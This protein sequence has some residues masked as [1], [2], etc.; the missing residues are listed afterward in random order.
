MI[1]SLPSSTLSYSKNI[2]QPNIASKAKKIMTKQPISQIVSRISLMQNDVCLKR[3][4]Q[5]NTL[6]HRS[7]TPNAA[8]MRQYFRSG[9]SISRLLTATMYAERRQVYKSIQLDTVLTQSQKGM[10]KLCTTSM[11]TQ[12]M[13]KMQIK[14]LRQYSQI[15]YSV[16]RSSPKSSCKTV[17]QKYMEQSA[18]QAQGTIHLVKIDSKLS[19]QNSSR[20]TSTSSVW[21][22]FSLLFLTRMQTKLTKLFLSARSQSM[23]SNRTCTYVLPRSAGFL[24]FS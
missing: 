4:N 2:V 16:V 11:Q 8:M 24:P 20:S 6:I 9:Y 5:S 18:Q 23:L 19:S 1:S 21:Q 3:R 7:I 13:R 12:Q 22:I 10:P 14:P 15:L 17:M